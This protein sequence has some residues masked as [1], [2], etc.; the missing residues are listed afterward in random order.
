MNRLADRDR[1]EQYRNLV[2][3]LLDREDLVLVGIDVAKSKHVAAIGSNHTSG[4]RHARPTRVVFSNDLEGFT[5]LQKRIE[6]LRKPKELE[7]IIGLEPTGTYHKAL[8][9]WL[10]KQGYTVVLVSGYVA[11][12][13]RITLDATWD[14]N[15]VKDAENV[16]DVLRQGKVKYMPASTGIY[17]ELK[18]I[19]NSHH[20]MTKE[21]GRLRSRLRGNVL[22][23]WFPEV[24]KVFNKDILHAD[25]LQMLNLYPVPEDIIAEDPERFA[26]R[27]VTGKGRAQRK[28]RMLKVHWLAHKSIGKEADQGSRDTIW[29]MV[30]YIGF[31][32]DERDRALDALQEACKGLSS[33]K[34]LQ[35]LPGFGPKVSAVTLASI[36]DPQG[37][38][39]LGQIKKQAGL[40]LCSK[41]SGSSI[42]GRPMISHGGKGMLRWALYIAVNVARRTSAPWKLRYDYE[43]S[44]R[45]GSGNKAAPM[46]SKVKLMDKMLRVAF[47]VIR[48]EIPYDSAMME[49]TLCN[50]L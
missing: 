19:I 43:V 22:S 17:A 23:I 18:V 2:K 8:T 33:Y 39:N 30:R 42:K 35:T 1:V 14:A 13:N 32:M 12:A 28:K 38:K 6:T 47:A 25:L 5:K 50:P 27:C 7:V 31:I 9:N 41:L 48:D 24:E 46:M 15:D 10:E 4:R 45:G 36:G 16:L 3:R 21:L 20:T 44:K 29:Q 26:S 40:N 11:N 49:Q 34:L 37:Y